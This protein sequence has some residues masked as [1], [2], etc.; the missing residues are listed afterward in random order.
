MPKRVIGLLINPIAGMGGRVGLKGTDGV[1]EEAR[2][3]GAEP[4]APGRGAEA[5][6]AFLEIAKARQE[7]GRPLEVEWLTCKGKMGEDSFREAGFE[8][9]S[10]EAVFGPSGTQD[11]T[12]AGDTR[13]ACEVF[14][15]K[16]VDLVIF[17]GGDGTARDVYSVLGNTTLML[18]IPSGVK[19]H[20][21]V[22]CVNTAVAARIIEAFIDDHLDLSQVEIMDLDEE[23]YRKGEW[24]IK[25]FGYART[26][27]E[28]TYIQGGKVIIRE[29]E[30][31]VVEDIAWYM[32]ELMEDEP[33]TLW[34]LGAGGT[35]LAIGEELGI[36]KSLL[37]IDAVLNKE[38]VAKDVNEKALLELLDRHP[39]AK[40]VVSPIGAQ[41]FI[42]GRGNLQLSPAVLKRI[43]V[44]NLVVV[45]TPAKLNQ[46]PLLRV[47]TG[48]PGLDK[49]FADKKHI[50][51][52]A[53]DHFRRLHPMGQ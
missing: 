2:S 17:V 35:L 48:D 30:E 8:D 31:D 5:L 6:K 52:I 19:M 53:G 11:A 49:E 26:P 43:G 32:K 27:Y 20:S 51:V 47:D 3:R 13:A 10:Y 44:D 18:G 34:I 50:M 1:I 45:A 38:M 16:G 21:G 39:K 37:G 40:L 28:P 12:T 22:F 24:N 33:D 42:L 14:V 4:V 7:A 25:L 29:A 15:D 41:G 9:G 23:L 36:Q 46:T